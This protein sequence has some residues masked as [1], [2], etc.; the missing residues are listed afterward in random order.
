VVCRFDTDGAAIGSRCRRGEFATPVLI[1][2]LHDA[3]SGGDLH[4][5]TD[6]RGYDM[7]LIGSPS[8]WVPLTA[9]S[10]PVP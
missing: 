8:Q 6:R 5:V 1:V 2:S 4:V 3:T 7:K 10:Y 9:F